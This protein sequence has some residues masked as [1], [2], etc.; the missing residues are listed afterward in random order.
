[1][2]QVFLLLTLVLFSSVSLTQ[3]RNIK[4]HAFSRTLMLGIEGGGTIGIND[5][6]EI[7]P[8]ILGR[9]LLEYFFPT[10]SSGI[11]S[12]RAF[13]SGG[14]S[15]G[16]DN[17]LVPTEFR[18]TL[19]NLGGGI[20][21]TFSVA[22]AVFPYAFAGA[23]YTWFSPEDP[24]GT[25]LRYSTNKDYD[26][27]EINFHGEVGLRFL[28]SE[29]INFNLTFGGQLSTNDN[30]DNIAAGGNND[31]LIYG[32]AGLSYSF[33]TRSD[34]DG[35]GVDDEH[36]SCPNTPMGVI[37]DDFGC[38]LDGDGDGV[39][40][41]LDK[42]PNTKPGM[43]V[44]ENGC[45]IDSDGD[46]VPDQL[47]KCPNT[48]KGEK[49]NEAGCPDSDGDGVF[50]NIDKCSNTPKG[51]PVDATGCPKDSDGD[52]VPD[53]RDDCPNTP[54]GTQVDSSGCARADT[55]SVVLQGD[56]NFEFDKD[57]LLPSAYPVLNELAET[58]KRN[59]DKRWRVE[60]HTDAI[61]SESYN[62]DLSG[63]RAQSV[64]DY[65]ISK[66]VNSTQLEA[67]PLGE[68]QPIATNDTQEGRAM[69]RR[70]EIELIR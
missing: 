54:A 65:L 30:W 47:D 21:Y 8:D 33:F 26:L 2:R 69:N 22:E 9:G 41:Y 59:R 16:K 61:G 18:V 53:Y 34:S 62:R 15:G 57:E 12:L 5:Y 39:P 29:K 10:T 70:V 17:N 25:R 48:A 36:D 11:L 6:G 1:M 50:D 32:L 38:P 51:A 52:G 7:R 14:Y 46:G 3:E 64:V 63:R 28:L 24:D 37:V 67:V 49:V 40:D 43:D 66:G 44:D 35:D 58:I 4:Y 23:S 20:A 55:V 31:F 60:G 68:S 19:H 27:S 56:T 13:A 42:C 45:V